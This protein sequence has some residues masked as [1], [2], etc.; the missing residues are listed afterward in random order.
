[1]HR[2]SR[3][4]LLLL[5]LSLAMLLSGCPG[6]PG[7]PGGAGGASAQNVPP[8]LQPPPGLKSGGVRTLMGTTI[9]PSDDSVLLVR[10]AYAGQPSAGW[11]SCRRIVAL[12][13]YVSLEGLNFD[14]R[15][16]S[17][18]KDVNLLLPWS[19][20]ASFTWKYEPK[21]TPPPQPKTPGARAQPGPTRRGR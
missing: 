2:Y 17:A 20:L 7:V 11:Q 8:G 4:L 10:Y 6:M 18:E 15:E 12:D 14:G 19:G 5:G 16:K 3:I 13:T 21:P 9:T 1:M